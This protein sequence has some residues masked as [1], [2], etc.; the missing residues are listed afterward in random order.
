MR[1]IARA[2]AGGMLIGMACALPLHA[3]V[4]DTAA[5]AHVLILGTYHFANPGLDVVKAEVTDVLSP[6]RQAEIA[7]VAQALARFRPTKIAVEHHPEAAQRLDSLYAAYR[8]GRHQLSR[9]E[10]EQLGFRL[11]AMLDH[12]RVYPIDHPGDFPFDAVVEYAEAHEPALLA[13]LRAELAQR[14]AESNRRQREHTVAEILRMSNDP[15]DLARDHG[16]YVRI[17]GL[18]AG[19]GYPGAALLSE[20]YER[21]VYIFANVQQLAA[22]G[23][24]VLVI[25]GSGHAPI[26]RELVSY[27]PRMVLVDAAEHL[28]TQ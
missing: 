22:P 23:E 7:A 27:D 15:A 5:P 16:A 10:T 24:R 21:N 3:Q 9:N 6:T 1:L 19:D 12:P 14:A 13:R 25:I 11:A 8:A 4:A 26:L 28:L 17:A 20:W 2:L 18:G